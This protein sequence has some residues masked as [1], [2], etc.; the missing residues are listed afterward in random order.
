MCS[1]DDPRLCTAASQREA[2]C[3]GFPGENYPLPKASGGCKVLLCSSLLPWQSQH[4]SIKEE[5]LLCR[6]FATSGIL[7][8]CFSIQGL[9]FWAHSWTLSSWPAWPFPALL[10]P[11]LQPKNSRFVPVWQ[12]WLP[13][14]FTLLLAVGISCSGCCCWSCHLCPPSAPSL[15]LRHAAL[16]RLLQ[17]AKPACSAEHLGTTAL[18]LIR[19]LFRCRFRP[20]V[21]LLRMK[22][23]SSWVRCSWEYL[24]EAVD[25][26]HSWLRKEGSY[27][28]PP[29]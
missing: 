1:G 2:Q 21:A 4:Q 22:A 23:K 26:S 3:L 5:R 24:Q 20:F 19:V 27:Q 17:R 16:H 18:P 6:P 29:A 13:R 28:K 8:V 25:L 14:D 15:H 7:W 12:L 10:S 11:T 9:I